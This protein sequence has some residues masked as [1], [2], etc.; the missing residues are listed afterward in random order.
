MDMSVA[1]FATLVRSIFNGTGMPEHILGRIALDVVSALNSMWAQCR[2][3]HRDIKPQNILINTRGEVKLCDFGLAREIVYSGQ[4]LSTKP[5]TLYYL[6]PERLRRRPEN[7]VYDQR[8][9][10][11]SLGLT[12]LELAIGRFPLQGAPME[13][14]DQIKT[15]TANRF[16]VPF[17]LGYSN[18]FQKFIDQWY[19]YGEPIVRT[20]TLPCQLTSHFGSCTHKMDRRANYGDLLR[21]AALLRMA[22][23]V[24]IAQYV[25]L[26]LD[27]RP[28]SPSPAVNL[29]HQG[30]EY[31]FIVGLFKRECHFA[32]RLAGEWYKLASPK[33]K[34]SST[35][36]V[37]V[38][39][40][41]LTICDV[42]HTESYS[43]SVNK[44]TTMVDFPEIS[45]SQ[46]F[47]SS[48]VQINGIV[49]VLDGR[50][51]K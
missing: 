2:L 26:V 13:I 50:Q 18:D 31:I 33:H 45:A 11:W 32:H 21:E 51:G 23:N 10:V 30:K 22:K 14:L 24:N 47:T 6:A 44:W 17:D 41:G 19:I 42:R 15:D 12:I 7:Q 35:N 37:V 20:Q 27:H 25:H 38:V 43:P 40:N 1:A 9:D 48:I 16:K 36:M 4:R 28:P 34:Y 5:G 49:H 3:I 39:N 8:A 46:S 29:E